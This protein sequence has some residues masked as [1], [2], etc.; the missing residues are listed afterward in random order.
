MDLNLS[1]SLRASCLF[2]LPDLVKDRLCR[3]EASQKNKVLY[4]RGWINLS[5]DRL[6]QSKNDNNNN[7][8]KQTQIE[9]FL[10]GNMVNYRCAFDKIF[11]I[12]NFYLFTKAGMSLLLYI[13]T[14]S[15]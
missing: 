9:L 2:Q 11:F 1:L 7:N 14:H 8:R 3:H 12:N 4:Q 10:F 6:F 13:L 15:L 5:S